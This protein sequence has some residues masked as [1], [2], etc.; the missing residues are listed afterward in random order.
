MACGLCYFIAKF[1]DWCK[2][3]V[4]WLQHVYCAMKL[5]E[6]EFFNLPASWNLSAYFAVMH[7]STYYP[8]T[9]G[10]VPYSGVICNI[11]EALS[12]R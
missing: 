4:G 2:Y 8:T 11:Q 10:I 6:K 9:V 5:H 3:S 1:Q 12:L 7:F